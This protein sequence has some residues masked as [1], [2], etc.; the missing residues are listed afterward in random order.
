MADRVYLGE[1]TMPVVIDE[2]LDSSSTNPVQNK[3]VTQALAGKEATISD[4]ATIRSGAALGATS[5]QPS[6][7][8]SVYSPTGTAPLNGVAVDSAL[9]STGGNPLFHYT[10]AD[11][12]FSNT[13]WLR[14]DSFSWQDCSVYT[15]AYQH[16]VNDIAGKTAET[17]TIGSIMITFYRA[18][19]GH[20][21]CL[22]NQ[23]GYVSDL[24]DA[25]GVAWYY[26]L[27]TANTRFKLPRGSHGN[28]V[29][30]SQNGTEGCRVYSDG[31][32][33]QW[34]QISLNQ[35]V[36]PG[37]YNVASVA[38]SKP[39]ANTFY[40]VATNSFHDRFNTGSNSKSTDSMAVY[41]VNDSSNTYT[42]S[43]VGWFACGYIS[44]YP[45]NSQYQYLYFYCGNT[46]QSQ[47]TI[48]V[49]QIT[50]TL[51]GKA[52]LDLS[53]VNNTGKSTAAG[54]GMPSDTYVDL[55][56]GASNSTY[57]AP[58]NGWFMLEKLASG[59]SQE[60]RFTNLSNGLAGYAISPTNNA[61]LDASVQCKKGD[62]A[63]LYYTAGGNLNVFRFVYAEGSKSEAN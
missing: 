25:T 32:C 60:L 41:Y 13:N 49:G 54:W 35:S 48:D 30:K 23:A 22:A 4:L 34:G 36:S 57:T 15:S 51:N 33:E 6:D 46:V 55:T 50:E 37:G 16:L 45:T 44:S 5:I 11:H 62:V 39:F 10:F 52:D 19:D 29:E 12:L 28:I 56:L 21:I 24:Y 7:V 59:N 8:T 61:T 18:T 43:A 47:T 14:A 27:D 3:V 31:W 40:I 53:N 9:S 58:A 1:A 63:R 17:E 20:K 42:I 38:F 2:A 26:I